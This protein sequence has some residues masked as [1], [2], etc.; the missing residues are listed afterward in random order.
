[1]IGIRE[2]LNHSVIR[3]RQG[4]VPEM[5]GLPDDVLHRG[6][7]V[8]IAHLGLAVEFDTLCGS[9]VRADRLKGW[10]RHDSLDIAHG[11]IMIECI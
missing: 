6:D 3:D 1:M 11:Q 4:L 8:H 5:S 2:R 9:L 10:N 7:S